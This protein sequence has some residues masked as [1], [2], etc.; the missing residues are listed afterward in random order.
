MLDIHTH[1]LP[2]VDDGC[3]TI[4]QS[5][6]LLGTEVS[7]GVT[8][9]FCTPHFRGNYKKS[10]EEIRDIFA[11]LQQAVKEENIPINLYLGEEISVEKDIRELLKN[12]DV[13]TMNDTKYVLIELDLISP[14]EANEIV[15]ALKLEGYKPIV[16]HIERYSYMTLEEVYDIKRNGGRIQVNAESICGAGK[17][18]HWK[19]V[20]KLFKENLVDYVASDIHMFRE[21]VMASARKVVQKKF[22]KDACEVV[23][24][25]NIKKLAK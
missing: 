2:G 14:C 19:F 13:L 6:E 10:P 12:G 21:N 1:I 23:F 7:N 4:E 20:K 3:N 22:G 18:Q 11:K 24:D 17:K 16:A 9:V 25:L 15:Y 8:D 5:L